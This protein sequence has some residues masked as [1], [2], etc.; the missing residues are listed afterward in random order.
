[1]AFLGLP[2][3]IETARLFSSLDIPGNKEDLSNL[4]I[5]ILCFEDDFS[6]N[7]LSKAFEAAYDVISEFKPFNIKIKKISCF[8]KREGKPC[9]IIAKV[10]SK[11]LEELNDQLRKEF[12]KRKIDYSKVFKDYKPHITLSYADDEIKDFNIDAIEIPVH[13]AVL[14][15]GN[16]GEND[17]FITF[18]FKCLEKKKKHSALLDRVNEFYKQALPIFYTSQLVIEPNGMRDE[19]LNLV[20][21]QRESQATMRPVAIEIYPDHP[22]FLADGRHRLAIARKLKDKSLKAVVRYYD[23]DANV[24]NSFETKL[25]IDN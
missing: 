13:E 3:K 4:H 9:P 11:D 22:P 16:K 6:I 25:I 12:N 15:G 8:P 20:K 19:S 14:L 17:V 10:E 2:I 21:K 18:P 1:M 7:D 5:T 23:N 24:I